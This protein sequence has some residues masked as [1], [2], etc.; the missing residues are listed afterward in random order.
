MARGGGQRRKCHGEELSALPG[1]PCPPAHR[2]AVHLLAFNASVADR[3]EG[4]PHSAGLKAPAVISPGCQEIA[5]GRGAH[6]GEKTEGLGS[7]PE[8]S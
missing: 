1:L 3:Q 8:G 2:Q 7:Q 4:F 6:R 5:R